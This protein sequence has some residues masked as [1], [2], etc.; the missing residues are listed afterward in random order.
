MPDTPQET[1]QTACLPKRRGRHHQLL[2]DLHRVHLG[3]YQP[4][5]PAS[6]EQLQP[7]SFAA[8]SNTSRC[9]TARCWRND[10]ASPTILQE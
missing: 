8:V 5:R 7:R 6:P 9:L 1:C 2:Q 3:H 10:A 4:T